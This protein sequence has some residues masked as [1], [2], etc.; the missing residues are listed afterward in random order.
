MLRN[1]YCTPLPHFV[2][3]L[4]DSLLL[5]VCT[6]REPGSCILQRATDA[7]HE[8][9]AYSIS[10]LGMHAA[11]FERLMLEGTVP[12]QGELLQQ[13]LRPAERAYLQQ[14][15]PPSL[16]QHEVALGLRKQEATALGPA[17]PGRPAITLNGRPLPC[18]IAPYG[19]S[20]A[21]S[22]DACKPGRSSP[23]SAALGTMAA[24]KAA[25]KAA[26]EQAEAKQ[27]TKKT[28]ARARVA[29]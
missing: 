11:P 17:R 25:K 26:A 16:A 12:L 19:S 1:T 18:W 15:T 10:S 21:N 9:V 8:H 23:K 5:P 28:K 6:P 3:V 29:F 4:R 13:A 22:S 7:L 14:R 2:R 24:K 27:K 20:A